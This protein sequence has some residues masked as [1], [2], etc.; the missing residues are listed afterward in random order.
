MNAMCAV[1]PRAISWIP[2]IATGCL[3][4]VVVHSSMKAVESEAAM[5]S[6][7]TRRVAFHCDGAPR[8]KQHEA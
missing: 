7:L 4:V 2:R 8:E 6:E 5:N 1:L 3:Y